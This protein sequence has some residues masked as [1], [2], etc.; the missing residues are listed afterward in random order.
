MAN[1]FCKICKKKSEG[2]P[3]YYFPKLRSTNEYAAYAGIVHVSCLIQHKKSNHIRDFLID[4]LKS[5]ISEDAGNPIVASEGRI[6]VQN[7]KY[8]ECLNVYDFEDFADFHVPYWQIDTL[9]ELKP[10]KKIDLGVNKLSTLLVNDDGSLSLKTN[11]PYNQLHL[12]SLHYEKLIELMRIAKE[13]I[14]SK[15]N[16]VDDM[17]EKWKAWSNG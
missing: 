14:S 8:D 7:K 16:N 17:M 4:S 13:K 11:R 12:K 1:D 15:K 5:T 3:V 2:R 10:N 9:L 6:L